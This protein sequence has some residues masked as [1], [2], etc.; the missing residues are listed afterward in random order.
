MLKTSL[1]L[2]SLLFLFPFLFLSCDLTAHKF[3]IECTQ[4]I[5]IP[6]DWQ[7][8]AAIRAAITDLSGV[9]R[10]RYWTQIT[11]LK[12]T[13]AGPISP[14]EILIINNSNDS[15][16]RWTDKVQFPVSKLTNDGFCI[17]EID[18][19]GI[20]AL[21]ISGNSV[22]ACCYGIYHLIEKIKLG[23]LRSD[24][25]I[26]IVKN[27]HMTFRMITEP[28]EAVGYET[29]AFLPKP[30][31]S[32]RSFDPMRPTEG[33]GYHPEDEARNILRSGLNVFYIGSYAFATLYDGWKKPL[34]PKGSE[35]RAWVLARR[36]KLRELIDAAEKY[37]LD[38]CANGDVFVFPKTADVKDKWELLEYS[39]EEI[40]SDYPQ[41]DYVMSRFGEN[42][43]FFNPYFQGGFLTE[44]EMPRAIDAIYNFVVNKH[45]RTYICRAWAIGSNTWHSAPERFL[46][47]EGQVA[48]K[49]RLIFS[50]KNTHTDFWRYNKFNPCIGTGAHEQAAEYICQDG[51]HYKQAIPY[52]EVLR[53]AR[54]AVE[55]GENTGMKAAYGKGVRSVWGWLLADGWCG[56]YPAQE[57]WLRSN[58]FGFTHLAW[59]VNSDPHELAKNWAA[60]EFGVKPESRVARTLANILVLSEELILK[61]RYFREHSLVDDPWSPCGNWMR[62]EL[63]G[64]GE[65]STKENSCE[66]AARP[67]TLKPIFNPKTIELECKEKE[68]AIEIVDRMVK[69][70]SAIMPQIPDSEKAKNLHHTLLYAKY[71]VH[72]A[73][74]Y[75][76]GMF[77]F[78]NGEADAAEAHPQAV[79]CGHIDQGWRHGGNM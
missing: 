39:L 7:S 68:E 62:D 50:F 28:F 26:G 74:H 38:I 22:R 43:S 8:D 79:G 73:A 16:K 2:Q 3:A 23:N 59:D 51:Y 33:A 76:I 25:K 67:G 75:S 9:L 60:I 4:A 53:M 44:E 57:E 37:H 5:V 66:R 71:F 36:A 52:Y 63:I 21:A 29:V 48:A 19:G 46:K 13:Q 61:I 27:P 12:H 40:L 11:I 72:S 10:K 34:H 31:I 69:D 42:Y 64:G 54:G 24:G 45:K 47:I 55:L 14:D 77:R 58:I 78:Y 35:A 41:I 6:H 56:P 65:K 17:K 20:P 18:E 30:V 15:L 70:F 49:D 1:S 32:Q